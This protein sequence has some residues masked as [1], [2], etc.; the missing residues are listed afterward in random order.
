MGQRGPAPT[1]TATLSARGSWRA[2]INRREPRPAPGAPTCPRH[3]SAAERTIWKGLCSILADMDLLTR[4]DG[5][6][7]ERYCK[8]LLRWRECEAFIAAN[9]VA[10]VEKGS[11]KE[12]PQVRETHRLHKALKDI[13]DRFGLTPSARTRVQTLGDS[14]PKLHGPSILTKPKTKLDAMGAPE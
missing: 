11:W 2:N 5:A 12:Y 4:A 10:Y 13:E 9:G 3:L 6:N 7:L 14:G 8:F 1:P